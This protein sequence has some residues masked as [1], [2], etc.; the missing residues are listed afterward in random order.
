MGR[1]NIELS[2]HSVDIAPFVHNLPFI[3]RAPVGWS[4]LS[5]LSRVF[6]RTRFTRGSHER[7]VEATRLSAS[8]VFTTHVPSGNR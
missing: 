8:A 5:G 1:G 6:G 4:G 3:A 2:S 7:Y